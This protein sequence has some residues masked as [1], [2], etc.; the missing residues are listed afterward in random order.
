MCDIDVMDSSSVLKGNWTTYMLMISISLQ[1][2]AKWNELNTKGQ[3]TP[4]RAKSKEI[5]VEC[6]C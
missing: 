4:G 5:K 2:Q 3:Q 6:S 1:K